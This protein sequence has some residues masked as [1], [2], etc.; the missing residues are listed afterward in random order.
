MSY[1]KKA[2]KIFYKRAG[3][4]FLVL[5]ILLGVVLCL[6]VREYTANAYLSFYPEATQPLSIPIDTLTK[7][8]SAISHADSLKAHPV[9]DSTGISDSVAAVAASVSASTVKEISKEREVELLDSCMVDAVKFLRQ[10]HIIKGAAISAMKGDFD[11]LLLESISN[12]SSPVHKRLRSWHHSQSTRAMI[13]L[14]VMRRE[15][16][17]RLNY[18]TY[19]SL[20]TAS[21]VNYLVSMLKEKSRE[22]EAVGVKMKLTA[23]KFRATVPWRLVIIVRIALFA[24]LFLTFLLA[25]IVFSFIYKQKGFVSRKKAEKALGFKLFGAIGEPS[26]FNDKYL[27]SERWATQNEFIAEQIAEALQNGIKQGGGEHNK[28]FINVFSL[29]E[30]TLEKLLESGFLRE[31]RKQFKFSVL[32]GLGSEGSSNAGGLLGGEALNPESPSY[33]FPDVERLIKESGDRPVVV[34]HPELS[35]SSIPAPFLENAAFNLMVTDARDGWDES[36]S[37]IHSYVPDCNVVMT[38]LPMNECLPE[39]R[40]K[41]KS[42]RLGK[43]L[44]SY[45]KATERY[46]FLVLLTE[47]YTKLLTERTVRS[48]YESSTVTAESFSINNDFSSKGNDAA[49]SKDTQSSANSSKQDTSEIPTE[50]LMNVQLDGFSYRVQPFRQRTENVLGHLFPQQEPTGKKGGGS[51]AAQFGGADFLVVMKAGC[52]VSAGFFE[53]LAAAAASG[54][55]CMQCHLVQGESKKGRR[56]KNYKRVRMSRLRARYGLSAE[57]Q[58]SGFAV[59]TKLAAKLTLPKENFFIDYLNNT[60]VFFL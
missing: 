14:L 10:R 51:V 26:T 13:K 11:S 7:D 33:K 23:T 27:N 6:T 46:S 18:F 28:K 31:L 52:K 48:L 49:K 12:P 53:D 20:S 59:A 9:A 8:S 32:G 17:L 50:E 1:R 40:S 30:G 16:G 36:A 42:Y 60:Y 47:C 3:T 45:P 24:L 37:A 58:T 38:G 35:S 29:Y 54:V 43:K 22:Y 19:D 15:D 56:P 5:F 44:K 21:T 55:K 4:V 25:K 39:H 41:G 34:I 57:L 2:S